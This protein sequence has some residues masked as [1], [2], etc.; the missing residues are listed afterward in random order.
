MAI[1][2]VIVAEAVHSAVDCHFSIDQEHAYLEQLSDREAVFIAETPKPAVVGFQSI[3]LWTKL[4]RSMDHVGQLGTFV[5]PELRGKGVATHLAES[6][7][8][9]A[10]SAAY[11]KLVVL[12]RA[13]NVAAQKFYANLGFVSCGRLTRQVKIGNLSDDEIVMEMFL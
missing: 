9:F 10:R 6:T 5:L 3:D 8:A 13:S 2:Q 4:F 12:V 11:E 1:W 7:L